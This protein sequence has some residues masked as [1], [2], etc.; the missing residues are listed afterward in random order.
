MNPR[1]FS[2]FLVLGFIGLLIVMG[3]ISLVRW[4]KAA[5][6][7]RFRSILVALW[8]LAVG[9]GIWAY[10]EMNDGPAF[11]AG[12]LLTLGQP[13]VARLVSSDR[14]TPDIAC[15][16]GIHEHLAVVEAGMGTLTAR[17][18]SNNKSGTSYCPIGADV[19]IELAWLQRF[20]LTRRQS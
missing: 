15:I 11:H 17:V 7:H 14:H 10:M 12:D 19:Q 8:L 2:I 6:P 20:T 1:A 18:E 4:M 3:A 16:V 9:L 13:V 5:Y